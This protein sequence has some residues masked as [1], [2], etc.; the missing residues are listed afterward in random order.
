MLG[1]AVCRE[2][3]V[4]KPNP[5][6]SREQHENDLDNGNFDSIPRGESKEAIRR[7]ANRLAAQEWRRLP[8]QETELLIRELCEAN[9]LKLTPEVHDFLLD[10]YESRR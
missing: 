10:Q 3:R 4:I 7:A 6:V 2:L 5:Y 1:Q 8:P 9:G